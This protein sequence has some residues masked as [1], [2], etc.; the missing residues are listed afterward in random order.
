MEFG[1]NAISIYVAY[2]TTIILLGGLIILSL[3][4]ARKTAAELAVLE[5]KRNA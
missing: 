1:K 4:R 5:A 2:G 3:R